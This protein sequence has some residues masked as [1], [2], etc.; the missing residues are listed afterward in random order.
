M[1]TFCIISRSQKKRT[2]LSVI[3]I[4]IFYTINFLALQ[5]QEKIIDNQGRDFWVT[6][7]ES[8]GGDET[9]PQLFLYAKSEIKANIKVS[10]G[11][12]SYSK[13]YKITDQSQ[14]LKIEIPPLLELNAEE[15]GTITDQKALHIT[16][17]ADIVLSA[18]TIRLYS[19]DAFL[20]L[21]HDALG[22][23]YRVLT[24]KNGLNISSNA[25]TTYDTPSQFA[26]IATED[27][28]MVDVKERPDSPILRSSGPK[29]RLALNKGEVYFAQAVTGRNNDLTGTE[30]TSSKPLVVYAGHKRSSIPQEVGTYRDFLCEQMLPVELW[31]KEAVAVPEFMITKGSPYPALLRVLAAEDSTVI[32]FNGKP[33]K[34]LQRNEFAEYKLTEPIY[35]YSE[36]PILV[37]QYEHSV[38]SVTIGNQFDLGDPFMML[39][40]SPLQYINQYTFESIE[41]ELFTRHFI[42]IIVGQELQKA[43]KGHSNQLCSG[44]IV[45]TLDSKEIQPKLYDIIGTDYK[46]AQI[47][48]SP[49]PHKIYSSNV[50]GLMVY[51]FGQANS[52]GYLGGMFFKFGVGSINTN[53]AN[54]I[55]QLQLK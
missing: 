21:P 43:D 54:K 17:D 14:T 47:E 13:N 18:V 32:Q 46:Y 7:M 37:M 12:G 53:F 34:T 30:I 5:A 41:S 6:F 8:L 23:D 49:G 33:S 44:E 3:F 20:C 25:D 1:Q 38:G 45:F 22:L 27:N 10:S 15:S 16:S 40:P 55:L 26:L 39:V 11:D 29:F 28:T 24:Y 50:F 51:G 35:V 4:S 31:R 2:L 52:Y 36:K 42:N 19:S 9:P 48:V